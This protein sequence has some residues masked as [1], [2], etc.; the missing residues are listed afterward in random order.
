M[1]QQYNADFMDSIMAL[2]MP[3]TGIIDRIIRNI[4]ILLQDFISYY[5]YMI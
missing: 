5:E 1:A 4:N 2:R 3:T